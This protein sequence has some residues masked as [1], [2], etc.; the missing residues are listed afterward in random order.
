MIMFANSEKSINC[1]HF[2]LKS[3]FLF[4]F[5]LLRDSYIQCCCDNETNV[6]SAIK[7]HDT[8]NSCF[9]FYHVFVTPQVDNTVVI[10][11]VKLELSHNI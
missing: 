1:P 2:E 6:K 11:F 4:L 8:E 10:T 5:S 3:L 7:L 9:I